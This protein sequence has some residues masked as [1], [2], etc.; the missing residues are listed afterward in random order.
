MA[1]NPADYPVLIG[2]EFSLQSKP[3]EGEAQ[4]LLALGRHIIF[5]LQI[6]SKLSGE[7]NNNYCHQTV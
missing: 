1:L 7:F 4:L 6:S 2:I 5:F 3:V